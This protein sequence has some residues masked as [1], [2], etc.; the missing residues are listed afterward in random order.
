ML[1]AGR[2]TLPEMEMFALLSDDRVMFAPHREYRNV[3]PS[4]KRLLVVTALSK[5]FDTSF[6]FNTSFQ[7]SALNVDIFQ[8]E[9]NYRTHLLE[10]VR[11]SA[12]SSLHALGR[13]HP[14]GAHEVSTLPEDSRRA[15]AVGTSRHA[16]QCH[17]S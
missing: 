5:L 1:I 13:R 14:Q 6:S 9:S 10:D 12:H 15:G 4:N 11:H 3:A 8:L 16:G 17:L 7:L 2:L